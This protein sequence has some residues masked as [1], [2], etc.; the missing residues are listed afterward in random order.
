MIKMWNVCIC[1]A[2]E[3]HVSMG[4]GSDCAETERTERTHPVT[5]LAAEERHE[6]FS[7]Q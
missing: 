3:I 5:E 4:L 2:W 7:G 1:E 6:L